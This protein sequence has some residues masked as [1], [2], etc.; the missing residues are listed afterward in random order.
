MEDIIR[1][2]EGKLYIKNK[3]HVEHIKNQICVVDNEN[4]LKSSFLYDVGKIDVDNLKQ[5]I[6][7]LKGAQLISNNLR[8]VKLLEDVFILNIVKTLKSDYKSMYLIDVSGFL[9]KPELIDEDDERKKKFITMIENVLNQ[10]K[11][12]EKSS[13]E[14]IELVISKEWSVPSLFGFLINYPILYYQ[15]NDSDTNC[16]SCIDLKVFQVLLANDVILS[17]SIPLEIYNQYNDIQT[18]ISTYIAQFQN[19]IVSSFTSNHSNINL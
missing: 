9:K 5:I 13:E 15:S 1:F 4:C 19:Y 2:K 18:H 17:F 7:K 12:Y 8:I 16:L 14:I 6:T 10:L 3:K 11:K